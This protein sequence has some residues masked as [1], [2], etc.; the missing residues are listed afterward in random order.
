MK[1]KELTETIEDLN[2]ILDLP[3]GG[4]V[5][6]SIVGDHKK[7][8]DAYKII[9]DTRIKLCKDYCEYDG[10]D[11]NK[12]PRYT[13]DGSG[14]EFTPEN[15]KKLEEEYEKI[16]DLESSVDKVIVNIAESQIKSLKNITPRQV[17]ILKKYMPK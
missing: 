1:N 10:E 3:L 8:S 16:L 17:Y 9:D 14:F 15:K 13:S 4:E 12:K 6:I 5:S 2:I 7:V 11:E